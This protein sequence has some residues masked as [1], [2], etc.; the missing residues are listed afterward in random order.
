MSSS[1]IKS[2]IEIPPRSLSSMFVL[3]LS[4]YKSINSFNSSIIILLIS[5]SLDNIFSISLIRV[6]KFFLSSNI[7]SCSI[8]VSLWSLRSSIALA[9]ITEIFNF[10]IKDSLAS[11]G[12]LEDLIILIVWSNLSKATLKPS[13][14]C[15]LSFALDSSK[16]NLLVIISNLW[17]IK[18]WFICFSPNS[19]GLF[20]S[21][22]KRIIP[23][24]V[25]NGVSENKLFK[26]TLG[27]SF[28]FGSIT[29]LIPSLLDSSLI[30]EIPFIFSSL[31]RSAIFSINLLLLTW[32]GISVI[33][34]AFVSVSTKALPLN[35]II[36]LPVE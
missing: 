9:W 28:L 15:N 27:S 36:P 21:M 25:L 8:P 35:L 30:S 14:K 19:W 20:L 5:S 10:L 26:I 33:T 17:S 11:L 18:H 34:I 2:S 32:Y 22:A 6:I 29:I 23:K 31:T 4:P 16:R 7:F 24:V 12:S 3:L 13:S 1:V